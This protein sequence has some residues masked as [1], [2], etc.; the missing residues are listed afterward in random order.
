LCLVFLGWTAADRHAAATST[1]STVRH[2]VRHTPVR[3]PPAVAH[4]G[5]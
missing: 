4:L 3:R 1:E 5:P 2:P